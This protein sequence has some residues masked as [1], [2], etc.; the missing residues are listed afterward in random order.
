MLQ[1][2]TSPGEYLATNITLEQVMVTGLDQL[3][4]VKSK[5]TTTQ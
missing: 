5:V 1:G 4:A 2:L 3:K